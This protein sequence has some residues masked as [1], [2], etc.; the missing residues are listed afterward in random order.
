MYARNRLAHGSVIMRR[1]P[2]LEA[3]G[4]RDV[5]PCEDYELW[6]RLLAHN[7]VA[8]VPAVLYRHRMAQSGISWR[9]RERQS[10]CFDAVRAELHR[11]RPLP[12]VSPHVVMSEGLAQVRRYGGCRGSAQAYA[13]DH[14]ELTK[15]LLRSGRVLAAGRMLLGLLLFVARVPRAAVG[16]PPLTQAAGFRRRWLNRRRAR[17]DGLGSRSA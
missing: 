4:Y 11:R 1:G 8:N 3:G 7:G 17:R 12:T 10:A 14:W 16:L 5:G 2:V 6:T 15:I 13:N 9:S